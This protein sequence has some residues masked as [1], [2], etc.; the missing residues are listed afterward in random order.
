MRRDARPGRGTSR[1]GIGG[2]AERA[3]VVERFSVGR[4]RRRELGG[5]SSA[6]QPPEAHGHEPTAAP[7]AGGLRVQHL[8]HLRE[9]RRQL[10][11]VAQPPR[12]V[13]RG[14]QPVAQAHHVIGD[15][16]LDAGRAQRPGEAVAVAC[17]RIRHVADEHRLKGVL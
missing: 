8:E 13:A 7:A 4:L 2:G 1:E 9:L 3:D 15:G 6:D 16:A 10:R 14:T 5:R 12:P 17:H 11:R